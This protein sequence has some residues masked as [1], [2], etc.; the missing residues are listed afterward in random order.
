MARSRLDSRPS[1]RTRSDRQ[2]I[3]SSRSLVAQEGESTIPVLANY[4][5]SLA[6]LTDVGSVLDDALRPEGATSI[7]Q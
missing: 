5:H 3:Q 2:I 7:L 6:Y 4:L 1:S